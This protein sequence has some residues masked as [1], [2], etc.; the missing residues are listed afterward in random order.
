MI[1]K[2][3]CWLFL[4]TGETELPAWLSDDEHFQSLLSEADKM[5]SYFKSKGHSCT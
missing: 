4:P 2:I 5:V 1:R 3:I